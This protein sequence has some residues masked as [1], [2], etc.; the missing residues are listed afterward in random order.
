MGSDLRL[1]IVAVLQPVLDVAQED[2]GRAQ[3]VDGAVRQQSTLRDRGQRRQRSAHAQA[4]IATAAHDLQRLHD[5]FDLAYAAGPELDVLCI[6]L[7]STLLADL[8]MDVAQA[9]VRVEIEV[10]AV[11][12][13]R[14]Q[15]VELVVP[16][17]GQ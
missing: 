4:R 16:R 5:E 3:A 15:G 1:P 17:A 14:D 2:I 10:L 12:E 9:L 7:A 6:V 13:R 8:A 11:D